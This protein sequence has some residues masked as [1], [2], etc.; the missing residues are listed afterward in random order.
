MG[1]ACLSL[2]RLAL[3]AV[4]VPAV[5]LPFPSGPLPACRLRFQSV[6]QDMPSGSAPTRLA[7]RG[8][9]PCHTIQI[10][11]KKPPNALLKAAVA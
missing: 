1:V 8:S 2:L 9:S 11:I 3:L 7:K 10:R 6:S 5:A 4:E